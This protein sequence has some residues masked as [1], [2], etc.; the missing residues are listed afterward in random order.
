MRVLTPDEA[1]KVYDILIECAGARDTADY[2]YAFVHH[3]TNESCAEYRFM[4]ALGRGGKFRNNH[5]GIYVDCYPESAR[6]NEARLA[7]VAAANE[8]LNA[9]FAP[10]AALAR[11]ALSR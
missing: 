9:L 11:S 8:R 2:R 3:T 6:E 5:N 7:M 4:G 1:N 10:D